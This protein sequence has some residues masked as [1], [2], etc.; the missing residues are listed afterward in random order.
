MSISESPCPENSILYNN[1]QCACSPGYLFNSTTNACSLFNFSPSEWVIK[2]GV[3]YATVFPENIFSLHQISK[4]TQS[5]TVFLEATVVILLSWL[6]F[7][8]VLRFGNLEDGRSIWFRIRWWISRLDVCFATRHWLDDHKV[9]KKRKTELGGAFSIA[10]CI[11]FIGLFAALLYQ[12]ISKRITKVHNLRA[13]SALDLISFVNDLEFN[14]TTVSTMSCS[15]LHGLRTIL[16]GKPG[17]IGYREANLST[18]ANH[19]CLNTNNGPT[20]NLKFSHCQIAYTYLYISWNFVDIMNQPASSVGFR[21]NLTAKNPDYEGH[22][23]FVSGIAKNG[24]FVDDQPITFRG[25]ETNVLQFNLFPRVYKNKHNMKLLQ[26]LFHEF[27][28]GSYISDTNKLQLSLQNSS[29]GLINTTLFINFLSDYV[30]EIDNQNTLSLVSFLADLGGLYCISFGI[31]YYVIVQCEYRFKRL[32]N[33]DQILRNIRSRRKAQDHWE[34]LR[35]YVIFT[36]GCKKLQKTYLHDVKDDEC[37]STSMTNLFRMRRS[38]H[39]EIDLHSISFDKGDFSPEEQGCK[40]D[41]IS[42][43]QNSIQSLYEYNIILRD[44]L[45]V[46]QSKL[47]SVTNKLAHTTLE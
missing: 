31:F 42:D 26:P 47:N 8:Y 38:L 46:V 40:A 41:G 29:T 22:I 4:F 32:C 12:M 6:V 24:S 34:K 9:V 17:I 14:I 1:S 11:L 15:Q 23:S 33:E 45:A 3:D 37:C 25:S 36:W 39:K 7:C 5:Q 10:S 30:I 18:F 20:I 27:L 2:S 13:T 35:K 19:S 16:I 43:T 44:K 21:F 28:P